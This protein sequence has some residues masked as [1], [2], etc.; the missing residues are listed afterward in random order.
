M[1]ELK[2]APN[3]VAV[4]SWSLQPTHPQQLIEAAASCGVDA[5]QLALSPI[6]EQ[7]ELWRSAI[8]MLREARITI[9]SG[10]MAFRG[11]DYSTLASIAATGGVRPDATW[12]TNRH[13]AAH[14]VELASQ[15]G[16]GLVTF[17][18]G[19][20][21]H[22]PRDPER[23]KL[24]DRLR[25][26]ARLF[27]ERGVELALETGQETAETLCA[28]L[29]ELECPNV[30]VNFDPANMILYGMGDPVA[31][32]RHLAK[33]VRQLHIKDAVS[34]PVAGEWG[35][36]VPAGEGDVD[37]TGMF[38]VIESITRPID[39]VIEREAGDHRVEDVRT[40]LQLIRS[41]VSRV[42]T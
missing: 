34:S 13:H 40:A 23:G 26:I 29:D 22:D 6:I 41:F 20:L 11:E 24:L 42:A 38:N 32:I 18:A 28:V 4:C 36:E 7:P 8:T 35:R 37:W 15:Y 27:H 30:G 9:V 25:I 1:P 14:V 19:F 2:N 16:I 10:M 12:P 33:H 31:A 3:R 5:V 39:L 21:P 17:H